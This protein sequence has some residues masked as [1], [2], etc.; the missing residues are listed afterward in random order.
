MRTPRTPRRRN[1]PRRGSTSRL[2]VAHRD[3]GALRGTLEHNTDLSPAH[4]PAPPGA[5]DGAAP[6]RPR[7]PGGG[8]R[9]PAV[10]ARSA[11]SSA[12]RSGSRIS[13]PP[14]R[15]CR[16][17][18]RAGCG[19]SHGGAT[20][21]EVRPTSGDL[22]GAGGAAQ[23]L[24]A[25]LRRLGVSR[26]RVGRPWSARPAW[27]PQCSA[28]WSRAAMCTRPHLSPE[29]LAGCA[30]TRTWPRVVTQAELAAVVGKAGGGGTP[31][32]GCRC[33]CR[34][35]ALPTSYT[36]GSTG[37]PRGWSSPTARSPGW[38]RHGLRAARPR[39]TAWPGRER[40]LRRRDLRGWG[41]LL[42]GGCVSAST[43]GYSF[44]HLFDREIASGGSPRCSSRLAVNHGRAAG[45]RGGSAGC[46]ICS[47]A[48]RR[49]IRVRSATCSRS[50]A[51]AAPQWL[52]ADREHDVLPSGIYRGVPPGR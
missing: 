51:G 25:H 15:P 44:P 43:R 31:A 46:A 42:T 37:R 9:L 18:S 38:S 13:Y 4:R 33:A 32:A 3:E 6:G 48:A 39:P 19:G 50:S 36:S 8:F 24:A 40:L 27:W 16:S 7:G 10:A 1:R 5:P 2:C 45:P 35:E 47:S 17:C 22:R 30:R 49:S 23:Q 41:A 26:D 11:P 20:A 34:P 12:E 21:V 52:W 28:R 29:R 14:R